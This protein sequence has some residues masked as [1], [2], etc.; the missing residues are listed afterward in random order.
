MWPLEIV[1]DI[2]QLTI[3]SWSLG[4]MYGEESVEIGEN[5]SLKSCTVYGEKP[6]PGKKKKKKTP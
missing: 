3:Q 4:R 6:L 5:E 1:A 2:Y